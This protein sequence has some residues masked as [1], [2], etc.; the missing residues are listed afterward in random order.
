MSHIRI[1]QLSLV[2]TT[3]ATLAILVST[4]VSLLSVTSLTIAMRLLLLLLLLGIAVRSIVSLL[5]WLS[6][7]HLIALLVSCRVRIVIAWLEA[8]W[9]LRAVAW[10]LVSSISC[11]RRACSLWWGA[12]IALS[13]AYTVLINFTRAE[14]TAT[15]RSATTRSATREG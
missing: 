2:P 3:L 12:V 9:R 13:A 11:G 6:M 1:H 8:C 15:T 4:V 10:L 7:W 14:H 5:R